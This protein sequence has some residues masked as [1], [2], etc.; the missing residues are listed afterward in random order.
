VLNV[1]I[2][3]DARRYWHHHPLVREPIL[4]LAHLVGP[5]G[6]RDLI[7]RRQ[8]WPARHLKVLVS[9]LWLPR[10]ISRPLRSVH[11]M[12]DELPARNRQAA[13]ARARWP[14]RRRR[15]QADGDAS[16]CTVGR[17][18]IEWKREL[19]EYDAALRE[20]YSPGGT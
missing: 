2:L 6:N 12:R 20:G 15:R 13:Q 7:A 10:D 3:L 16:A 11:G 9:P 17:L 4:P 1:R 5:A 14:V 19:A 8:Q 18:D